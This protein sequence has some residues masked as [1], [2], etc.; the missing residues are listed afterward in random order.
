M[1]ILILINFLLKCLS[2]LQNKKIYNLNWVFFNKYRIPKIYFL[3]SKFGYNIIPIL[4]CYK[5]I[6]FVFSDPVF[7]F[8]WSS[9]DRSI[10]FQILVRNGRT[11]FIEIL[12]K[13]G[14]HSMQNI[15]TWWCVRINS[16]RHMHSSE[17]YLCLSS[18]TCA[19]WVRTGDVDRAKGWDGYK[20]GR[21]GISREISSIRLTQTWE[22]SLFLLLQFHPY[23]SLR[24]WNFSRG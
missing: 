5:N 21:G 4:I 16:F 8:P 15:C 18:C 13:I 10:P 7:N 22:P 11:G 9:S 24:N 3:F 1:R 14:R 12:W 20:R 19:F 6:K 17:A 2:F 23:P